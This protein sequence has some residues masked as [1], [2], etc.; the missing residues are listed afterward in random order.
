MVQWPQGTADVPKLW[1]PGIRAFVVD[2]K[3]PK[4]TWGVCQSLALPFFLTRLWKIC[5][6]LQSRAEGFRVWVF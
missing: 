5:S 4:P 3:N 2:P 1:I 6:A